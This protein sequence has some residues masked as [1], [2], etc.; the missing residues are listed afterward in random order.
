MPAWIGTRSSRSMVPRDGE[1]FSAQV[2]SSQV[3]WWRRERENS[4]AAKRPVMTV[5]LGSSPVNRWMIERL[6]PRSALRAWPGIGAGGR[7]RS[8][9]A[10]CGDD[11]MMAAFKYSASQHGTNS[12]WYDLTVTFP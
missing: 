9:E 10:P 4:K 12:C 11:A 1:L 6:D 7:G 2:G 3:P 8:G 5:V